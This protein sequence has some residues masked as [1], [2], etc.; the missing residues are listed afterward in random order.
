[1][2]KIILILLI[3]CTC[4]ILGYM[5]GERFR[6]RHIDLR[7]S[8][9]A[10]TLLQNEVVFNNTPLPEALNDVGAKIVE[11]FNKLLI[12]VSINLTKGID[13]NVYLAFKEKYQEYEEDFYLYKEDK[14]V[15]G[16]F[17]KSL[18]ETGVYGQEKIFKLAL[19]NLKL[20]IDEA[21]DISKKNTKLYR[22]LGI[23]L[24]A[25]ISIFLL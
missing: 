24:G 2:L 1:M 23:C 8:Y 5:Y 9:K 17:L 19:E 3:F 20:N 6:K 16:D 21:L 15:L 18:G 7:E 10:L 11:P 12:D 13:S 25:M 14:S 4:S 22:Y